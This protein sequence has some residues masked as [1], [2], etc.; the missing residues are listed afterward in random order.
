MLFTGPRKYIRPQPSP[1]AVG[2]GSK[3]IFSGQGSEPIQVSDSV[4][5]L[6]FV[7]PR[8]GHDGRQVDNIP[9]TLVI[10]REFGQGLT[11]QELSRQIKKGLEDC[12]ASYRQAA[13]ATPDQ[14]PVGE[15]PAPRGW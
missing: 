9:A 3:V 4:D 12:C 13:R 8:A 1:L 10:F 5:G 7:V 2:S 11:H 14:A 15:K 6:W